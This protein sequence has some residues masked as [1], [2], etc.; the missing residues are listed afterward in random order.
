[1]SLEKPIVS[2]SYNCFPL[3]D[4]RSP[5]EE[6]EINQLNLLLRTCSFLFSGVQKTRCFH[7]FS[8]TIMVNCPDV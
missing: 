1:M 8:F 4:G 7:S 6:S 3:V 5:Q 2:E